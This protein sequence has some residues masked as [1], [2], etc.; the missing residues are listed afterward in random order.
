MYQKKRKACFILALDT[1]SRRDGHGRQH[2]CMSYSQRQSKECIY[3]HC[4]CRKNPAHALISGR[5]VYESGNQNQNHFSERPDLIEHRPPL[6]FPVE[7]RETLSTMPMRGLGFHESLFPPCPASMGP[8]DVVRLPSHSVFF[9]KLGWPM[10]RRN[11]NSQAP[12]HHWP[13][14]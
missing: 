1:T 6:D 14:A 9:V 2:Y 11:C 5:G 10:S 7:C 4:R 12:S 8:R 3:L 13:R